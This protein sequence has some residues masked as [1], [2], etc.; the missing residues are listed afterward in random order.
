MSQILLYSVLLTHVEV[1]IEIFWLKYIVHMNVNNL[2]DLRNDNGKMLCMY[3]LFVSCH[4]VQC[5]K[6]LC[7]FFLCAVLSCP[8]YSQ[9]NCSSYS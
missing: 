4:C 7:K 2:I 9:L 1:Y 3:I 5:C 6:K 8:F